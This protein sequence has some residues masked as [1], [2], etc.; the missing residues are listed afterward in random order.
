[1]APSSPFWLLLYGL[2]GV[3]SEL[4]IAFGVGEDGVSLKIGWGH[5]SEQA[6]P[7]LSEAQSSPTIPVPNHLPGGA[8]GETGANQRAETWL[9]M[10]DVRSQDDTPFWS[11]PSNI[12]PRPYCRTQQ[13]SFSDTG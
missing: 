12:L 7:G 2:D 5:R 4:R 3:K 11:F 10:P 8:G 13:S 9:A 6:G 1:M